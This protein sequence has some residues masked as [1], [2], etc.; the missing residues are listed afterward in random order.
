[1]FKT[2]LVPILGLVSDQQALQAA[3]QLASMFDAHVD[4]LH[5]RPSPEARAS[6]MIGY[7]KGLSVLTPELAKFFDDSA[8]HAAERARRTFEDFC[9]MSKCKISDDSMVRDHVSA[10]FHEVEGD[11]VTMVIAAA[12]VHELTVLSR[13]VGLSGFSEFMLGDVLLSCG[14][15]ILLTTEKSLPTCGQHVAIAWKSTAECAR[16]I[17]SALPL[18][19][20]AKKISLLSAEEGGQSAEGV[21]AS[22]HDLV[23]ELSW[24]G[25]SPEVRCL[26]RSPDTPSS[27]TKEAQ[28]LGAD[29]LVMGAY[30][31]SLT[32]EIFFGGFTQH[33]LRGAPL[34]L[35]MMH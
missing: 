25:L 12:K 28:L 19:T 18:L 2:I 10:S 6:A 7:V 8:R 35:F 15:P 14:R 16:A 29:L 31:H 5:V 27:I 13:N 11:L 32:R 22:V 23:K 4:C 17:T 9:T 3:D 20:T 26:P 33:V 1:M 34:H 21:A 24:H 30:G